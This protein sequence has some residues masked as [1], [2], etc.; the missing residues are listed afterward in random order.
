MEFENES[1]HIYIQRIEALTL[2]LQ[3]IKS[4]LKDT[5]SFITQIKERT[6]NTH[7]QTL[8][9]LSLSAI[10]DQHV[11]DLHLTNQKVDRVID[12]VLCQAPH[13]DPT[14]EEYK[15]HVEVASLGGRH[16][17]G[18]PVVLTKLS[19]YTLPCGGRRIQNPSEHL[20]PSGNVKPGN[21]HPYPLLNPEHLPIVSRFRV[22]IPHPEPK[23]WC[24]KL[25]FSPV[26]PNLPSKSTFEIVPLPHVPAPIELDR[27]L[28]APHLA[29]VLDSQ[30]NPYYKKL[31]IDDIIYN[32]YTLDLGRVLS[33]KDDKVRVS[34][35]AAYRFVEPERNR[36][37]LSATEQPRLDIWEIRDFIIYTKV[38]RDNRLIFCQVSPLS[39]KLSHP[40]EIESYI[41]KRRPG[42]E[43]Q[44]WMDIEARYKREKVLERVRG[45]PF[46]SGAQQFWW[47]WEKD[48]PL[49]DQFGDEVEALPEESRRAA[50]VA[51]H[52]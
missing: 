21:Y 37:P 8:Q 4:S 1:Y 10:I 20:P 51:I 25:N 48:A 49:T 5:I 44:R 12:L 14:S 11:Q 43:D 32:P 18:T 47:D 16:S 33:W 46:Q 40:F 17:F 19:T 39:R 27:Q 31:E 52:D 30:G 9:Q 7:F 26:T 24:N 23:F 29:D 45:N 13:L 15:K 50:G 35:H 41:K 34:V 28:G 36:N 22:I 2:Q 38:C 6:P 3:D 42:V